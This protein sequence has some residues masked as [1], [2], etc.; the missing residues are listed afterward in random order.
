MAELSAE[1]KQNYKDKLD[2]IGLDLDH[3]PKFLFDF[4]PIDFRPYQSSS[5]KEY[6]VYKYLPIDKIQILIANTNRLTTIKEK[7]S[8]AKP[9]SAFLNPEKEEDIE[10]VAIFLNML[11]S[12]QIEE[13]KHVEE[14]QNKLNEKMP[15]RIKYDKNYLWQ[16]Y[17][18]DLSDQYFM[19]VPSQGIGFGP[20][21]YLLK[22]QIEYFARKEKREEAE[23]PKIYIPIA[24]ATHDES[25]LKKSEISDLENYLWLFTA[26]WPVIYE[27]T[28]KENN[29]CIQIVGETEVYG[30]IKTNYRISLENKEEAIKLYKHIKAL[31]I[32]QTELKE[33]YKFTTQIDENGNLQFY[34]KNKKIGYEELSGFIKEQYARIENELKE[35]RKN[36]DMY[37]IKLSTLKQTALEKDKEFLIKQKEISTYLEYKKTFLGKVKYFFSRSQ[38]KTKVTR[39]KKEVEKEIKPQENEEKQKEELINLEVLGNKEYYTIEDLVTLCHI[40]TKEITKIKNVKADIKAL[41]LKVRNMEK[42]IENATL[43]IKEIDSHKKSIFEFWKFSSKDDLPALSSADEE[44]TE[45]EAV[46]KKVFDYKEDMEEVGTKIDRKQGELLSKEELDSIF[47]SKNH[48]ILNIFNMIKQIIKVSDEK[49]EEVLEKLRVEAETEKESFRLE[50]FDIFGSLSED[51]TKLKSL[52][53]KKHR[54]IE[55][56]KFQI[57]GINKNTT[58]QEFKETI[59]KMSGLLGK[60]FDK[61]ENIIDMSLYRVAEKE[62]KVELYGYDIY[63][64]DPEKVL[65]T[66]KLEGEEINLYKI[67]V[68]EN[69]PIVYFS[70]N[71]FF[72]NSNK[73]LP[74]GM[75]LSEEAVIDSDKFHF[76]LINKITFSTNKYFDNNEDDEKLRTKKI[77][78]Y[79]YDIELKRKGEK[80]K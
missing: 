50:E 11:K 64:I 80:K 12:T 27:V 35:E 3:I 1:E 44:E 15:F 37:E 58:L 60:T 38:S 10:N 45:T 76:I 49:L 57:L 56:S 29:I 78:L 28:N 46:L 34:F 52:N 71:T 59:I 69:M 42:K 19:L 30:N 70:N 13:I 62:E 66:T 31:F 21:F 41:E 53:G 17:Y 7:Y 68:S 61:V 25:I 40:H 23:L 43:Y 32:L 14:K 18:S 72:D 77:H 8:M 74:Q 22:M 39:F 33:Y 75:N 67:N 9:L 20:F 6:V 2:Y 51:K 54:E 73:T 79:E 48:N 65:E 16:I 4:E 24:L 36:V 5:D 55:K 47:V 63:G 26:N